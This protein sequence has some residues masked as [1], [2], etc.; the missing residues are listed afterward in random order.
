M[1][2]TAQA[3][4]EATKA[5]QKAGIAHAKKQAEVKY[6]GRKPSYTRAQFEI[7]RTMLDQHQGVS[8]IAKATDL[9]RQTI[10]R[11][12][13]DPAAAQAVLAAWSR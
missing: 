7:V 5:A 3:Q 11:I 2:A 13:I 12:E 10:Y 6:R 4:A 1:A 9:S 8:A